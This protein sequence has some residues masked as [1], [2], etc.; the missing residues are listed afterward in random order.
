M[1]E[2]SGAELGQILTLSRSNDSISTAPTSDS[3]E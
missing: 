1:R 2:L 3:G